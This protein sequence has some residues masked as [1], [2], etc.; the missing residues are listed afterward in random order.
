MY[1]AS[2]SAGAGT[3][4]P[5]ASAVVS[6]A[7][8][9][10]APRLRTL[11]ARNDLDADLKGALKDQTASPLLMLPPDIA[12]LVLDGI[13]SAD[14]AAKSGKDWGPFRNTSR[15]GKLL[16]EGRFVTR[17]GMGIDLHIL[18]AEIRN[19]PGPFKEAIAASLEAALP[20]NPALEKLQEI[21]LALGKQFQS[22]LNI[23]GPS[24]LQPKDI[25]HA[26]RSLEKTVATVFKHR[27]VALQFSRDSDPIQ[28][29]LTTASTLRGQPL[30]IVASGI[31][32]QRVAQVMASL[33]SLN[34]QCLV[35]LDLQRNALTGADLQSLLPFLQSLDNL[36]SLDLS[37][38]PLC[39]E[40]TC[41]Q[42]L[43][44]LLRAL[45]TLHKLY[46]EDIACN[47]ETALQIAGPLHTHP[48]LRHLDLQGNALQEKGLLC[49][50]RSVGRYKEG[51][52]VAN[53]VIETLRLRKNDEPLGIPRCKKAVE[54]ARK[55]RKA[56]GY[57]PYGESLVQV[58]WHPFND[59]GETMDLAWAA[60]SDVDG[61]NEYADQHRL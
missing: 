19:Q 49:L 14:S 27:T 35:I 7:A 5:A 30:K 4:V 34:L 39:E 33:E 55:A 61:Q 51:K 56:L 37:H 16:L 40:D 3:F 15:A 45:P 31:G 52:P 12:Y 23:L 57:H 60:R 17:Y 59:K 43:P 29:L 36:T 44:N 32:P 1:V 20:P 6:L 48:S 50:I 11:S 24:K 18:A 38:N 13:M 2:S 54:L 47:D 41:S 10:G 21:S 46:L 9:Q 42:T 28:E 8:F 58:N 25:P 22:F 53:R 26:Q